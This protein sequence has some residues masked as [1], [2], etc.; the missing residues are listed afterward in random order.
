MG[1]GLSRRRRRVLA[2]EA[3]RRPAGIAHRPHRHQRQFLG[4]GRHRPVRPVLGNLLRPRRQDPRRPARLARRRRRPLHRDLE[5]RLHAVRDAGRRRAHPSAAPVDRHRHGPRARRRG[6]AGQA[7]QLRHRPDAG[8][9]PRQRRGDRRRSRRAAEGFAPRRRR[10]S[11]RLRL[12]RRRRRA[13]VQ[14][15]A[16]LCPAPHHAPRHAPRPAAGRERAADVAAR[17]GADARNG[18]GLSRALARRDADFGD[19]EARGD[20]LP[21]HARARPGDP[22]G[23]DARARARRQ[24]R[25]RGRVQALRHLW[26]PARSD[27]GR[28]A[29]ARHG[30]RRR[31]FRRG[32][33]AP[34]R[35]GAQGL[36]RLGRSGDR[37][38]VV[39]FARAARRDRVP[40]LRDRDRRGRGERD[41]ARRRRGRLA[42][43]GRARLAR[44]QPD[45]V[46]RRVRAARSATSA[47]CSRPACGSPCSTRRSGSAT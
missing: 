11:A 30:R 42:R 38:G 16:R 45:A 20:A 21:R 40:R 44:P 22:G 35:R 19:A 9:D 14:R 2:V 28:A 18:A 46:L 47:R 32:D 33:G 12:P 31:R 3:H 23:G 26:L 13:A 36:G 10:P 5:S 43:R 7:R 1:D 17:A 29:R 27:P 34:A 39:F 8:A 37:D 24:A 41:R 4:D 15:G 6:A 25:R